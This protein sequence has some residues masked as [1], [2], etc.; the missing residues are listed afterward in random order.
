MAKRPLNS[1]QKELLKSNL[2]IKSVLLAVK[3][4]SCNFS[5]LELIYQVI[6]TKFVNKVDSLLAQFASSLAVVRLL[7]FMNDAGTLKMVSSYQKMAKLTY[8]LFE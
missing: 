8:H 3:L 5:F 1:P 2:C 7:E 4:L 6:T